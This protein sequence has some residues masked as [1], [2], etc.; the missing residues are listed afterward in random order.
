VVGDAG[1]DSAGHQLLLYSLNA[2]AATSLGPKY[3]SA[4]DLSPRVHILDQQQQVGGTQ[5]PDIM[6][7]QIQLQI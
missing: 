5:M 3:T 7:P 1:G 6:Q 4:L 2:Q